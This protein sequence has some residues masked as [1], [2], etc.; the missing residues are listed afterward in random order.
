MSSSDPVKPVHILFVGAG[1]VG[2][3]YASRLHH[4]SHNIYVSLTA[5]SNYGT[6]VSS[7]VTLQT[8]TF[9]DYVF[10]PHSVFPSVD[11]ANDPSGKPP[12]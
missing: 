1:A 6:I 9:G 12:G 3:F 11:A 2:C 7:G 5:R 8:H 10:K 4:P